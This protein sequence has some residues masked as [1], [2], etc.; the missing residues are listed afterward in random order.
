MSLEVA[1]KVPTLTEFDPYKVKY[2]IEV[3]SL[4]RQ[5]YNYNL[6]PLEI[7]LSGSVG[8]AKS[9]LLA[10]IVV[11]H[12]LMH[13]G[14]GVLIGRRVIRDGLNTI[15]SMVIKHYPELK[16]Y[17]KKSPSHTIELPN[18][19]IIYLVSWDKGDFEKF[20]SYELSL[21]VIE[22]LTEN[23][24]IDMI[25]EIRMRLGR[26]Q[27]VRENLLICATNPSSPAHPAYQYFIEGQSE[28]RRV[29]YSK[30]EDNPFLP[31]WYIESL[32]KTLDPKMAQRMLHG[33]W[34]EINR[35]NVY[36]EFTDELCYIDKEYL[37]DQRYPLDL[38]ID[39]NN[40]K[41]GKPM[42]IGAGQVIG[43]K[44]HA[45]KVWIIP[46]MRTLDIMD[47]V[48]ES[49]L[50]NG[51]FPLIRVFG[52][53]SGRAQDTRS[54]KSDWDLIENFLSN[55]TTRSGSRLNYEIEVPMANPPIKERHNLMNALFKNDLG[56]TR[57]FVY[58]DAKDLAKGFRLTQLK[59]NAR[60]IE[61]DSLREQHITTAAGYW[62]H[63]VD[64]ISRDIAPLVIS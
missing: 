30:T 3:L 17:W 45:A 64:L 56:Q 14:A 29:F 15:W 5:E 4:I 6:G 18:G 57:F 62:C 59:Q 21:A 24:T 26:A 9:L 58:R 38:F 33:K 54:N 53:A 16:Q 44:Y 31:A 63:R 42:S 19:S 52:D 13:P 49:G 27:G 12:A 34:I 50:L 39:F 22:E 46:G 2:Q 8:S 41:S 40:S 35:D 1:S 47:E 51:A 20:R 36:Y 55:Y 7:L 60:L 23:D 48:A 32:R 28:S 25:A 10:H 43:E 11:T 61:D 37:W